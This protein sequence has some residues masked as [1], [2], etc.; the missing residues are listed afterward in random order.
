MKG[1]DYFAHNPTVPLD[2]IAGNINIDMIVMKTPP[3]PRP[4]AVR[5]EDERPRRPRP[6]RA[7]QMNIRLAT[8]PFPEENI[9]VRSDQIAFRAPRHPRDLHRHRLRRGHGRCRRTA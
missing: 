7:R 3:H 2:S 6:R 5:P 1:A 4:P 9:F 8:D